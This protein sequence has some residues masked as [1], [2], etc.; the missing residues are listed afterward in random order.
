TTESVFLSIVDHEET[1]LLEAESDWTYLDDGTDP[2]S[3][4]MLPDFDDSGWEAGSAPLGYPEGDERDP[5][6]EIQTVI[7]YGDDESDKYATSYF[8]TSFNIDDSDAI[9]NYGIIDLEAD[10]GAIIY[11]NGEEIGRYNMPDGEA[12]YDDHLNDLDRENIPPE[13]KLTRITLDRDALASLADGENVLAVEVRQDSP[14]SSD[15]Y[16]DMEFT[17]N[18]KTD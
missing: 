8:R 17:V 15:V 3:D 6:G 7:G 2:G 9:G 10:D 18:L 4:W 1:T 5:F 14:Q 11:L 16:W 13:N 12:E